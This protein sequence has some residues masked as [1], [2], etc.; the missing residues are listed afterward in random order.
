MIWILYVVL[1]LKSEITFSD[2]KKLEMGQDGNSVYVIMYNFLF[3]FNPILSI[4]NIE[5]KKNKFR[6]L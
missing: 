2:D 4:N 3:S 5:R 6:F 1:F